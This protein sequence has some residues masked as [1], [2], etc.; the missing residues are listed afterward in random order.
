MSHND[1]V[2]PYPRTWV[3]IDLGALSHNLRLVRERIGS[4]PR[5][6]LV[7]KADAYGHGIVP[8]SRFAVQH[9]ADWVCVATVQEGTALRDAGLQAPVAVVSPI[10]AVEAEQAVFYDLR[11][12][13]ENVETAR[14]L[15]EAAES[16]GGVARIH[17]EV[18]SGLA[19][20]GC[21]PEDVADM[22]CA[23]SALELVELEGIATHFSNSGHDP[24]STRAQFVRFQE[25][26]RAAEA[27]GLRFDVK[28]AANSAAAVRYPETR[29]DLV[30]VGVAAYGIDAYDLFPGESKPVLTWLARVTAIR[31][32]PTGSPVS[33]GGTWRTSRPTTVATLGVGYG[34][35]YPRGL[36]NRGVV[37]IR[38]VEAPVVG[39]VNMDQTMIDVT[40]VEGVEIGDRAVLAGGAIPCAR[41]AGLIETTSH[42]ITTRIMSRVPRRFLYP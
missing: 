35:G 42:E 2:N 33:Y 3:E 29:L 12:H 23:I 38:G 22:A 36:S 34:D 8:V 13:V 30:R 21:R 1:D 27:R 31:R 26:V 41:L 4:E 15:S 17:L 37:E 40:D 9:G 32:L 20:F 6:G 7:T 16:Q 10:L 24:E 25:A 5:I 39:L 19:R 14:A 28:H 18:D 11:V